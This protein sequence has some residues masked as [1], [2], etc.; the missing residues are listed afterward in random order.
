M[1]NL[2]CTILS[3]LTLASVG[4]AGD[5]LKPGSIIALNKDVVKQAMELVANEDKKG[6]QEMV[7]KQNIA[8]TTEAEEILLVD[9]WGG[10]A[11]FR[12]VGPD[13]TPLQAYWTSTQNIDQN[14]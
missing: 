12:V 5:T 7:E 2:L 3:L 4:F 10:Y 6:L 1:K 11:S 8:I 14:Q 9:V 13:F